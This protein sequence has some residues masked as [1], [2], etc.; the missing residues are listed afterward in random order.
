MFGERLYTAECF[1]QKVIIGPVDDRTVGIGRG[2]L[3]R[4][5]N[6]FIADRRGAV[7]FE[8]ILVY[9]FMVSFLLMPLAELAAAGF[10]YISARSA[11]RSFGQYLQY[12]PP[13]DVTNTSAWSSSAIAKADPRFPITSI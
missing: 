7:A 3:V 12:T 9:A 8:T 1:E 11:L 4:Y 2:R 10:Q 6:R 13:P 5:K